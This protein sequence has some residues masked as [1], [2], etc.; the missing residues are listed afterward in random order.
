MIF[1]HT[2]LEK[3]EGRVQ[4]FGTD[5]YRNSQTHVCEHS[6]LVILHFLHLQALEAS[7]S[8]HGAEVSH[9]HTH[10]RFCFF[11][12]LSSKYRMG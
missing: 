12:H 7:F 1:S 3:A 10:P 4:C 8:E 5:L 9:T 6:L 2:A 11:F